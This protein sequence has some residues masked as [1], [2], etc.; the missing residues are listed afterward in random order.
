MSDARERFLARV[1]QALAGGAGP[2][3]GYAAEAGAA[4]GRGSMPP[5]ADHP[6]SDPAAWPARFAAELEAVGGSAERT[7]WEEAGPRAAAYAGRL[8]VRRVLAWDPAA[9]PGPGGE[10]LA[11]VLAWLSGEGLEVRTWPAEAADAELGVVVAEA[12]IAASGTVMLSSGRGKGRSVS[13][14][15]DHLLALVPAGAL[16]P[17]LAEALA[18]LAQ[19]TRGG[20]IPQNVVLITGPSKSADIEQQLIQGVHGPRTVHAL[21]V[22][23]RGAGA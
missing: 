16:R 7:A 20:D 13:L 11:S 15:P 2:A 10:L 5:R 21:L 8:G 9:L 19:R 17:T 12:A 14:L 3:P 18:D 1:R 4:V 23:P 22:A 6:G